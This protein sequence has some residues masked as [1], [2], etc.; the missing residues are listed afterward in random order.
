MLSPTTAQD[1]EQHRGHLTSVA[2]RL[3]GSFSDAQDAVQEAWIRLQVA[4]SRQ[5]SDLEIRELRGWL[6][7]VVGRICLDHLKSAA[8]RRESY[9]GQWLPEPIVTP[10]DATSGAP[11]ATPDPLEYVV[12]QEQNRFAALVVLDTLTPA[13]RVAFVLHDG[14]DVPFAEVARILDIEVATA[15][16]LASRARKAAASAPVPVS[17]EEHAAAVERLV[18][19]I[20]S[21][22]LNAVIGALDPDA[23]L[24]GDAGGT[25]RTAVNIVRGSDR[26]ARF[27]LG[28]ARKY[29]PAAVFS[30]SPV[31]VNGQLGGVFA[32]SP[33]DDQYPQ[34]AARVAGFTVR[35][36][37]VC[38]AY[39]IANPAKFS[40]V[41]MLDHTEPERK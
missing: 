21:G 18:T 37:V 22:D 9:V 10:V 33:G 14:F 7:T 28:L 5:G 31:L 16:Q 41:P 17:S 26:V 12:T 19:A 39:D 24:I 35:D 13:Q 20:A 27:Y 6:T 3:T 1:F 2:Y 29:G 38:A 34:F 25:T 23:V 30:M 32:G 36:G 40:A 4:Q 8:V 11:S 15:R